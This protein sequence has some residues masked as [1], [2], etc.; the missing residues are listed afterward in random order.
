MKNCLLK[1]QK[2]F[3]VQWRQKHVG[4]NDCGIPQG[5][6]E[7]RNSSTSFGISPYKKRESIVI[8]AYKFRL[9]AME[10]EHAASQ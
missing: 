7:T 6:S 1:I 8:G 4:Q 2:I 9:V 10:L 5:K 3:C